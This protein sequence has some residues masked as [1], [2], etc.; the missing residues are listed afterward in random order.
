MRKIPIFRWTIRAFLLFLL[1]CVRQVQAQTPTLVITA[2]KVGVTSNSSDSGNNYTFQM[3]PAGSPRQVT[4]GET[5]IFFGTWPNARAQTFS[6]NA[7]N[8]WHAVFSPATSC[9][10]STAEDHGFFYASNVA[11]GTSLVTESSNTFFFDTVMDFARFYNMATSNP[12]DV[13]SCATA[14][15]PVNNT[16]P[17]ITGTPFTT[18]TD[19]D[20]II[21]CVYDVA[22][23][24]GSPNTW[25]G[26]TYPANFSGLSD[27]PRFGH[28]CA[29]WIQPIHGSFT[30][31]FTVSQSTHDTFTIISAAF[32]AGTG[33]SAPGPGPSPIL[34]EM[35]YI[36]DAG[37]HTVNLPCP[38]GTTNIT[39]MNEAGVAG[40]S[41][42]SVTD[43][44]SNTYSHPTLGGFFPQ[45]Y[46]A[47]SPSV[48]TPNTFT[49]TLHT[50][51]S[52]G[53]D[54]I[55]LFCT[56]N[57]GGM[58][59]GLTAADGATLTGVGEGATEN[60]TALSG[61][62]LPASSAGTSS[63]AGD[64]VYDAGT[65]GKGPA[66]GCA[67][68]SCVFDYVGATW[69]GPN[70]GDQEQYANGDFM[71]HSYGASTA[72]FDFQFNASTATTTAI[73]MMIA[74]KSASVSGLPPAPPTQLQV[75]VH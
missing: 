31:T 34:S 5:I 46:Y 3:E 53:I 66:T 64:L 32:K 16:A 52:N 69:T 13:S 12:L 17:N 23:P 4:A 55:G 15:T 37:N 51:T 49:L 14:V 62:I 10:D 39:V 26:I 50:P 36:S 29:Y 43:S 47:N 38:A 11:T 19:G 33:G 1:L 65:F 41:L 35:Q 61:G 58:D 42:T 56:V 20:L 18:T 8:T 60:D 2:A 7:G 59:T 40:A 73:S 72:A 27:E 44:S 25:N 6:D 75:T 70:N 30:P 21:T 28:A 54:L 48:P 63:V 9:E 74:L 71:A 22:L 67:N 57:S 68:A 24:L 45:I